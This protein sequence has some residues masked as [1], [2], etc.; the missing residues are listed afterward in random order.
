MF[1]TTLDIFVVVHGF[2]ILATERM[3]HSA[4]LNICAATL[5]DAVNTCDIA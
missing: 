2:G 5:R 3:K 4:Q 1:V